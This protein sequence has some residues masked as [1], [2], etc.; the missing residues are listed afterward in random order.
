MWA[1]LL[2]TRAQSV[3]RVQL[4]RLRRHSRVRR[5]L[6]V[7]LVR[8]AQRA[9]A[10]LRA[11]LVRVEPL[12]RQARSALRAPSEPLAQLAR[13]APSELPAQWV[14]VVQPARLVPPEP[15][16]VRRARPPVEP[17]APAAAR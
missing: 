15:A 10:V 11:Q 4:S 9:P 8:A 13:A 3:P 2:A 12:V 7:L 6:R 16:R 17:R 1:R 5:L 14:P